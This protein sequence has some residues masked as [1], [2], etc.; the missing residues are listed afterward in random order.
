M[1]S[2]ALSAAVTKTGSWA[3]ETD[4]SAPQ[5]PDAAA[6]SAPAENA[7]AEEAVT[8]K[9]PAAEQSDDYRSP[10]L[11]LKASLNDYFRNNPAL[12]DAICGAYIKVL[13]SERVLYSYNGNKPLIPA[14]NLKIVT[15]AAALDLLGPDCRYCTE[16]WGPPVSDK[17]VISG[18]LYRRGNADPTKTPP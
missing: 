16:V 9:P 8:P 10:A 11:E 4:A 5:A 17:G 1:I 18:D 7:E 14:S 3:Q 2:L 13:D 12:G 15:T 6:S